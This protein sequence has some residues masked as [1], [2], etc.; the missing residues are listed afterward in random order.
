MTTTD[1][2]FIYELWYRIY[3]ETLTNGESYGVYG[4]QNGTTGDVIRIKRPT[5]G[6]TLTQ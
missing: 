5:F 1:N 4:K 3:S 6:K 2:P